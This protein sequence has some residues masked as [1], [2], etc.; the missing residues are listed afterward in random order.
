MPVL[1]LIIHRLRGPAKAPAAG[2][3]MHF[4]GGIDTYPDLPPVR[5]KSIQ[6]IDTEGWPILYINTYAS[7]SEHIAECIVIIG[8]KADK[9][10]Y[11]CIDQHLGTQIAGMRLGVDQRKF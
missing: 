5:H 6:I 2:L 10:L 9:P 3:T 4:T 1:L 7:F 11:P 8:T